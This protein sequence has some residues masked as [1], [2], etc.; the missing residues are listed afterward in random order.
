MDKLNIKDVHK[1]DS[2]I[3][4]KPMSETENNADNKTSNPWMQKKN[5]NEVIVP[6][7]QTHPEQ[8][9]RIRQMSIISF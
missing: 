3:S 9:E 8:M 1:S 5:I 6:K 2:S 7:Q 4:I